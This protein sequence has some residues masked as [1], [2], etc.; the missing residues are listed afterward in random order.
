MT[1]TS[2]LDA[3]FE[4]FLLEVV[5]QKKCKQRAPSCKQLGRTADEL[6]PPK[7]QSHS[8]VN[9]PNHICTQPNPQ[10][11]T[12]PESTPPNLEVRYKYIAPKPAH[13]FPFSVNL[14]KSHSQP[15]HICT[16]HHNPH[17]QLPEV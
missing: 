11:L 7:Y 15:N 17:H 6:Q 5:P 14:T 10:P 4:I 13:T 3:V 9:Q 2:L 1:M 16:Q 12:P 8:P